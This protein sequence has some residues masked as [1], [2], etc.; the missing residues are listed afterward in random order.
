MLYRF[1][2]DGWAARSF[3]T[4]HP[5]TSLDYVEQI[6]RGV[7][8]VAPKMVPV[9]DPN[10]E[11]EPIQFCPPHSV[12]DSSNKKKGQYVKHMQPKDSSKDDKKRAT[13]LVQ[14]YI[15]VIKQIQPNSYLYPSTGID[16]AHIR[17]FI[18][19]TII[20][21]RNIVTPCGLKWKELTNTE[22]ALKKIDE[23][24]YVRI[25]SSALLEALPKKTEFTESEWDA[26][27]I[28]Q[29]RSNQVIL[30]EDRIFKP[31]VR[32]VRPSDFMEVHYACKR[33]GGFF[34]NAK[35][36]LEELEYTLYTS[37]YDQIARTGLIA[38]IETAKETIR[39][40]R[41]FARFYRYR[42]VDADGDT[43]FEVTFSDGRILRIYNKWDNEQRAPRI[44]AYMLP[45][46][47]QNNDEN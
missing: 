37:E 35:R 14:A 24:I 41:T 47:T 6:V 30:V 10:G 39:H 25:E 34:A 13:F 7:G 26:F 12:D 16:L 19:A 45:Q 44:R 1:K 4:Q 42:G 31:D 11:T 32:K 17:Q 27:S 9:G 5:L 38:R 36:L 40:L 43:V 18:E 20:T 29:L 22:D 23:K 21:L 33:A 46:L 3:S 28:P 8:I 2:T 15:D